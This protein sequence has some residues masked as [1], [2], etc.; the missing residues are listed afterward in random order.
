MNGFA[1]PESAGNINQV[2]DVIELLMDP[3]GS[4]LNLVKRCQVNPSKE[5]SA[6]QIL[7][8]REDL[9][10]CRLASVD[11]YHLRSGIEERGCCRRAKV[12]G[13]TGYD[14]IVSVER[15]G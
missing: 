10:W 12:P 1:G 8:A 15:K 4:R 5:V 2:I 6:R 13:R 9:L 7:P 14:R 11:Q 3:S